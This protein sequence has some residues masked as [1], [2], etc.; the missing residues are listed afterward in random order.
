MLIKWIKNLF[1]KPKKTLTPKG[2]ALLE[3]LESGRRD[4]EH[5]ENFLNGLG[6]YLNKKRIERGE[7]PIWQ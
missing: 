4:N 5:Y 6:D 7:P 2:E 3:Y 1:F